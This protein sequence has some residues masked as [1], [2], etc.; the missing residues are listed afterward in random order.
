[1]GYKYCIIRYPKFYGISRTES[2]PINIKVVKYGDDPKELLRICDEL[3][4]STN[5]K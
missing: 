3:N 2:T 1:M 4:K 5:L